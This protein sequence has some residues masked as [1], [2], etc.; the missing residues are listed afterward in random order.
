MAALCNLHEFNKFCRFCGSFI[1]GPK[2]A[3]TIQSG[4]D[5]E[6][7]CYGY[8]LLFEVPDVVRFLPK[9]CKTCYSNER[10]YRV[11]GTA[12]KI[13]GWSW[14][15]E[16]GC[17]LCE[18]KK[19]KGRKRDVETLE[20]VTR[21]EVVAEVLEG[22]VYE[23]VDELVEKEVPAEVEVVADMVNE[24]EGVVPGEIDEQ[25]DRG[26]PAEVDEQVEEEVP[27]EREFHGVEGAIPE[28][29]N[30]QV[31]RGVPAEIE[32]QVEGVVPA[33]IVLT[34]E[35]ATQ[36]STKQLDV[37]NELDKIVSRE[38]ITASIWKSISRIIVLKMGDEKQ[39]T[40]ST[41]GRVSKN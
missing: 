4:R 13:N 27:A 37:T 25:V 17:L 34:A 2:E 8:D 38:M 32:K 5:D 23:E 29:V 11:R 9:C 26:V 31:D 36:Q 10:N 16:D 39:L 24:V 35:K 40:V 7:R 30:E 20:K 28:D 41:A 14:L 22:V 18:A 12:N 3:K 15:E 1:G 21:E 19:R 33:R 6:G